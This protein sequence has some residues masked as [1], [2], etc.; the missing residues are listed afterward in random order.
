MTAIHNLK[1]NKGSK[2]AG[3]DK[4]T[5]RKYLE[6][7]YDKTISEVQ[8]AFMNYK[9]Q[10]VRRVWI[11]KVGKDEFR[12][13]GIPTIIDRIVQEC[14][15][16]V[17]EPI[18]EGR[19]FEHS[20]GFRPMR[21]THHALERLT[22]LVHKTGYHWIVEGDISKFFDKVNHQILI[23]ELYNMGI[24][25]KRL[26]MIIKQMLKAGIMNETMVSE[27]GTPQGGIL[28]PL[29]ANVY[30]NKFDRFI[31]NSW[32]KFK[33]RH[34]YCSDGS[35]LRQ[36]RDTCKLKPAFLVRYAD[37]WCLIT[38]SYENAVKWKFAIEKWL[39][40]HLK[41]EL[42]KDKTLITNVRKKKISFLG[43][44]FK[45]KKSGN[46]RKGFVTHTE[47]DRV[48]IQ[49][50]RKELMKKAKELR[51]S[52]DINDLLN[53]INIYNSTIRGIINYYAPAT[54]VFVE[55]RKLTFNLHY[56]SYKSLK[57]F[58]GKWIRASEV[59]NLKSIHENYDT[60]IP[61]VRY[62]DKWVGV[63]STN[64]SKWIK[65]KL[66]NQIET[67]YSLEGRNLHHKITGK[68]PLK[69]RADELLSLTLSDLIAKGLTGIK[70]NFEYHL[71]RPYVFN[72]DK[73]KCRICRN[74]LHKDNVH[75]HHVRPY[76]LL[77]EINK[78]KNLAT[79]CVSCHKMIH[80]NND[81]S[82]VIN[83][84]Q[85]RKLNEYREKLI[86]LQIND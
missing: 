55:L 62:K 44:T 7:D 4:Y 6:Q 56:A 16:I 21:N 64:F 26:L 35:K 52:R 17:I 34:Q 38:D 54:H 9:A 43:F 68:K 69:T 1:A 80:N 27:L 37:D 40:K 59:S 18:C 33:T 75:I 58:G 10:S 14:I 36:L 48:R 15:R 41:L 2:T 20:Y 79:V 30:L 25:D 13:L 66:K 70:Y 86:I 83:T 85:L 63:T 11:P 32:K 47:P 23:R 76:L 39:R 72:V 71:N 50:K 65:T 5:I 78:V 67:P 12:P 49:L 28:S 31:D 24:A 46:A 81:Y 29:L 45:V 57:R 82:G 84:K 77:D 3:I 61:A 51:S 8:Q 22:S 53:N 42:S 19:F 74:D 73:G 60:K